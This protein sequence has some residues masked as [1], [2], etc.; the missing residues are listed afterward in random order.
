MKKP[1]QRDLHGRGPERRCRCV[2]RRRLQRGEPAQRE[3]WHISYALLREVANE[4]IIAALRHVV[5]VLYADDLRNC[6]SLSQL[7]GADITQA[8]MTNQSLALE[9]GKHS[10]RL[11][12]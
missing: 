4:R 12:N 9:L 8:E 11:L 5:E 6:L 3:E 1:G 10:Q 7:F 2:Q